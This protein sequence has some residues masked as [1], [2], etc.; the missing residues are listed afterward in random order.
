MAIGG[1]QFGQRNVMTL[2]QPIQRIARLNVDGFARATAQQVQL[3]A[4]YGGAVRA[5]AA[6]IG[7]RFQL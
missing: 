6:A 5:C 7:E 4:R 2:R 3:T 1:H